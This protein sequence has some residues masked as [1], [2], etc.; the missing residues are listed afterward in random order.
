MEDDWGDDGLT[1]RS[2]PT[3]LRDGEIIP[4]VSEDG[5]GEEGS[6]EDGNILN[7]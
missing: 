7:P 5:D 3:E 6:G 4:A 1:Y 2:D